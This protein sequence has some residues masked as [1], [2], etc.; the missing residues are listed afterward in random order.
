MYWLSTIPR[1]DGLFKYLPPVIWIYFVPMILTTLGSLVVSLGYFATPT[2]L[3][4]LVVSLSDEVG[5]TEVAGVL[6]SFKAYAECSA[7]QLEALAEHV[8]RQCGGRSRA[9]GCAP[10]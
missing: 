3:L 6:A 5:L 8:L 4:V 2:Y 10:W 7:Q 9:T 1:L